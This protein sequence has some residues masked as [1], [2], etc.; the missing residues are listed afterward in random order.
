MGLKNKVNQ[1]D[2]NSKCD[3][4]IESTESFHLKKSNIEKYNFFFSFE[5][6]SSEYFTLANAFQDTGGSKYPKRTNFVKI[7]Y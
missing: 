3:N 5:I 1:H 7:Y 2:L 4:I 6:M